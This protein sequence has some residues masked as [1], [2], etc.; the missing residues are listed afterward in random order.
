MLASMTVFSVLPTQPVK[1]NG[2]E[3]AAINDLWVEHN[4]YEDGV[5]G[6]LIH[7]AFTAY[8]L[9]DCN[10]CQV[11]SYFKFADGPALFCNRPS[12]Y[13][14]SG[15]YL[16]TWASFT[17]LYQYTTFPDFE[18]FLPYNE[19]QLPSAT[20]HLM[21]TLQISRRSDLFYLDEREY[22]FDFTTS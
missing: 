22:Y 13:C 19:I 21:F 10:D 3:S 11:V 1:A 14:T 2:F 7:A 18:L 4:V 9:E 6:I 8:N 15:G 5:K 20:W 16:A 17:P 12:F